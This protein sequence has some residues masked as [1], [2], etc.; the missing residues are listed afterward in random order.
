MSGDAA[1]WQLRRV[2]GSVGAMIIMCGTV[3]LFATVSATDSA[4]ATGS[5][6]V[7]TVDPG[8]NNWG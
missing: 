5:A 6:L 7:A 1:R 2:L 4:H 3:N 8:E